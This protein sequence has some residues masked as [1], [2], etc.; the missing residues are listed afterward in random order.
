[1]IK[2]SFRTLDASTTL[3]L[4]VTTGVDVK[5][6]FVGAACRRDAAAAAA[7]HTH[8]HTHTHNAFRC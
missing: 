4:V 1:M 7:T 5:K 6:L 2:T 8:T 3:T